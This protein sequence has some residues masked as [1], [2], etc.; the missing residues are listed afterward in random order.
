MLV[1]SRRPHESIV[2]TALG[3]TIRVKVVD[4]RGDRVRLGF[5]AP[6]EVEIL[7]QELVQDSPEPG[8]VNGA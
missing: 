7:R 4:I 5:D 1:L 3:R 2:I 6:D 8:A